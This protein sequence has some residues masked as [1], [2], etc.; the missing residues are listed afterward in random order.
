MFNSIKKINWRRVTYLFTWVL[1][2]AGFFVLMGFINTKKNEIA[3]KGVKIIV[4]GSQ[5]FVSQEDVFDIIEESEG[6]LTGHLLKNVPIHE[7]ENKLAQNPFI[8]SVKVFTEM[9]GMVHVKIEQ[10]EAIMRI[11]NNVGNDFYIDKEGV[12]FPTSKLYAPH[13]IV[14]NGNVSERFDGKRDTVRSTLVKDLCKVAD[15]LGKDSLW[16]SQVEQLYVNEEQDIEI[17]PRVGNQKIVLG[18]ADSLPNK[19]NRL[20]VFYKQ[21][22][23]K[24]GWGT[25]KTVNLKF[26]N[27]IVCEKADSIIQKE[28]NNKQHINTH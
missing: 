15:F 27:Q 22:I 23:P 26:A 25:Y 6:P 8:Q 7:L 9:D 16:N 4:P 2:L 5:A 3:C 28:K 12:K 1:A 14:A 11:I 10:R 21:I 24:A 20:M 13:I 19:F 18:N 17:V